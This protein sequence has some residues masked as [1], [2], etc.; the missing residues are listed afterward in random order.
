MKNSGTAVK[1]SDVHTLSR[2]QPV[3][4]PAR[5]G[6][7]AVCM[8]MTLSAAMMRSQSKYSTCARSFK[9]VPSRPRGTHGPHYMRK[10]FPIQ[11]K[12]RSERYAVRSHRPAAPLR[13]IRCRPTHLRCEPSASG[14]QLKRRS[15]EMN[16]LRLCQKVGANDMQS[17][18]IALPRRPDDPLQADASQM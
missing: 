1:A 11:G 3:L 10:K 17:A 18:R 12:S 15:D 14:S 7:A 13:M 8:K 5:S 16:E 2:C 4:M 9:A 6:P